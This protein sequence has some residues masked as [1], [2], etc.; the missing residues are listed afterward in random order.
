M[1]ARVGA[2]QEDA[3]L[4]TACACSKATNLVGRR[5]ADGAAVDV[6]DDVALVELAA[7]SRAVCTRRHEPVS[8]GHGTQHAGSEEDTLPHTLE[9]DAL[10]EALAC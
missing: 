7:P 1:Q 10:D 9:T 6:R 2:T 3:W 8:E 5:P 4:D